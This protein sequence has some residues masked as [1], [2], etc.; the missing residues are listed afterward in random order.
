MHFCVPPTELSIYSTGIHGIIV[1][2][3]EK[4]T[5]VAHNLLCHFLLYFTITKVINFRW[6]G[7]IVYMFWEAIS[8]KSMR[9]LYVIFL[10]LDIADWWLMVEFHLVIVMIVSP[11][12]YGTTP[13][14]PVSWET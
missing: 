4:D 12:H 1:Q 6:R 3:S 11:A 8:L 9:R 14:Q 2:L 7:L 5:N 13:W 10:K